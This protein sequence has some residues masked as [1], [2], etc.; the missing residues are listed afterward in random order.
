MNTLGRKANINCSNYIITC[1]LFHEI[2]VSLVSHLQI[3]GKVIRG[4]KAKKWKNGDLRSKIGKKRRCGANRYTL[5]VF[6]IF[7]PGK[8]TKTNP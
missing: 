8:Q 7:K 4:V 6:R 3:I 5:S 1:C 2:F